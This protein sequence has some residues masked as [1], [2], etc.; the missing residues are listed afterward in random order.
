[1]KNVKKNCYKYDLRKPV[2]KNEKKVYKNEIKSDKE[3]SFS[4]NCARRAK[5]EDF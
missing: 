2:A 4:S 5:D 1:V 3:V